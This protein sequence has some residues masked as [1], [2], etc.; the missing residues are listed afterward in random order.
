MVRW[1]DDEILRNRIPALRKDLLG[2]AR[3]LRWV[4]AKKVSPECAYE[5]AK[6]WR[7]Q[8]N[9]DICSHPGETIKVANALIRT[10]SN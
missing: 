2:V 9:G 10:V 3:I 7:F 1:L 6:D 4:E 8:P 5:R